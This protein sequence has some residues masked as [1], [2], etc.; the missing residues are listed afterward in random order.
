MLFLKVLLLFMVV[1]LLLL[2][3][4]HVRMVL[5]RYIIICSCIITIATAR[6]CMQPST[7]VVAYV[8]SI[9]VVADD[10]DFEFDS[11]AMMVLDPDQNHCFAASF[12]L[13]DRSE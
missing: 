2:V 7:A 4:S 8:E 11:A 3:I 12:Y 13:M 6:Y 1:L 9:N 5:L 10:D